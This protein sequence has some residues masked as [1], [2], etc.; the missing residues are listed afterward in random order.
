MSA[1]G[2]IEH[3]FDEDSNWFIKQISSRKRVLPTFAHASRVITDRTEKDL[4]K[5]ID[6]HATDKTYDEKGRLES[7]VIEDGYA[8]R[9]AILNRAFTD[10]AIFSG[11]L[12]NMALVSVVSLFDAFLSRTLR[13]VYKAKPEILNSCTRQITFTELVNFGSVEAAREYIIDKEIETLL[14]DSHVAQ[15]EWLAKRLDVTLTNLPAWKDFVELTERRNLLVHADG[16]ASAHYIEACKKHGIKLDSAITTGT[17][18]YVP[19]DYYENACDCVAEIGLKLNQVIWRKLIPAELED[20]EASF[21]EISYDLLLQHDYKLAERILTISKEKAFKKVNAESGFYMTINLGIALKGQDKNSELNKLL[22]SIDF[23]ALSTKFKL[24]NLILQD[25]HAAAA[26]L[27][28]RIGK[29]EEITESNYREWP[30]FRWFRKT[31]EFKEAYLSIFDKEFVNV[32]EVL[33]QDDDLDDEN[34][35]E[36]AAFEEE[37]AGAQGV[38]QIDGLESSGETQ[39]SFVDSASDLERPSP[40]AN[41][42]ETVHKA[43]SPTLQ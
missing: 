29:G 19:Q 7:Y 9:H 35:P 38:N 2:K 31:N 30:L 23:S 28:I 39:E 15:F 6:A 8:K 1:T 40:S 34:E 3:Q 18:L 14:R 22:K 41:R 27:M 5:L 37:A 36:E 4:E 11:S 33:F 24:A 20:A 42:S 21:I 25:Q 26:E 17:K 10:F 13:N 12:P 16:K 43:P 32:K